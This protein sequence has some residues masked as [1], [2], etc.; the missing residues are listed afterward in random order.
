MQKTLAAATVAALVGFAG[1]A[2]AADLY[3]SGGS[4]KDPIVPVTSWTG[5]YVGAN[6][7]GA[8]GDLE[9]TNVDNYTGI[10][11]FSN[12]PAGVLVGG[13]IGYNIQSGAFVFGIEGDLGYMDLGNTKVQPLSPGGDTKSNI[14]GGLYGDITARVGYSFDKA[15]VYAKGGYAFYD[16]EA[17]VVDNCNTGACGGALNHSNKTDTLSGWVI[18]GGIEYA[19]SPTYSLK[20]EYLHYEFDAERVRFVDA[21]YRWD[22]TLNVDTVKVGINYHIGLGVAPLK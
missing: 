1:A 11:K 21:A 6:V 17:D 19:W 18:G 10:K 3:R 8:W 4:L 12:D 20:A 15:L 2:N 9:V 13:T 22:N 16:G 14:D 7:G 5:F